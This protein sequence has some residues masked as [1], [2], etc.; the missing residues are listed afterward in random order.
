MSLTPPSSRDASSIDG[1]TV[2]GTPSAGETIVADSATAAHWGAAGGGVSIAQ[3]I[4]QVSS[5]DGSLDL[6]LTIPVD[7]V[8]QT[9]GELKLTMT[10]PPSTR[11]AADNVASFTQ[12]EVE[13]VDTTHDSY[14]IEVSVVV[15]DVTG[16]NVCSLQGNASANGSTP[17]DSATI[18]GAD[19]TPSITGVDLSWD[20]TNVVTAAGGV[21]A[22]SVF[23]SSVWD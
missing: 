17:D 7:P 3:F 20:G 19:L 22:V 12:F 10:T 6:L 9:Y 11:A 21:Y 1:V 5:L 16:A 2:T 15:S 8:G 23:Y 4:G 13:H 14:D 18:Q